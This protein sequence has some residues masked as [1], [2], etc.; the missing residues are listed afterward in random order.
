LETDGLPRCPR[1]RLNNATQRQA[2]TRCQAARG[3]NGTMTSEVLLAPA[4][5]IFA[6]A[7][8]LAFNGEAAGRPPVW[9]HAYPASPPVSF[10]LP[11]RLHR[12]RTGA[13]GVLLRAPVAS[14]LGR[15]PRLRSFRITFG[16]RYRVGGAWR[17]YLSANCPLPPRF[18]SLSIPLARV[19]YRFSP[20]P[21]VPIT[22]L[23]ACRVRA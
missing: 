1:S 7:S 12:L 21:T 22:I 9:R 14:V 20:R 11:F 17:S 6:R 5:P 23:R 4:K 3:G 13:Y 16:R 8:V 19:T 2:L 10:V 18:H 15:W